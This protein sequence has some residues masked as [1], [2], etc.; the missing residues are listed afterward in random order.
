MH[1]ETV[2]L[3]DFRNYARG[4]AGFSKGL[5]MIIGANGQGKTNLLEA[6]Q[7]VCGRGSHRAAAPASLVRHGAG[8]AIVRSRGWVRDR[9]IRVDTLIRAAGGVRTQLNGSPVEATG[10]ATVLPASVTFSPDDLSLIKGGPEER[11]K[12]LDEIAAQIMPLAAAHRADFE[13]TLRQRNGVLKAAAV[14]SRAKLQLEVWSEQLAS[15]A[16]RVLKNRLEMLGALADVVAD[17]YREVAGGVAKVSMRYRPTWCDPPDIIDTD[18]L[19]EAMSRALAGSLGRDLE[20]G[21]T[22][23]GPHRDDVDIELEGSSARTFAS[24]GEQRSL[25]LTLRLAEQQLVAGARKELPLL[26]LDDV[27]SELDEQ[28]RRRVA[29]VVRQGGQSFLTTTDPEAVPLSAERVLRVSR[30]RILRDE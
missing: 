20:R 1:L 24:Q 23:V 29:E 13:K 17:T 12:Y 6:I 2:D 25:A 21:V 10:P 11:R 5:N 8:E 7:I 4:Q 3:I 26:L 28:R 18:Q 15:A 30:G 14:S 27:F 9:Q 16:A 19:E 22:L